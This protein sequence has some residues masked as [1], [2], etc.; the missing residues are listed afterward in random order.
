[1]SGFLCS[2]EKLRMYCLEYIQCNYKLTNLLQPLN[3]ISPN[4]ILLTLKPPVFELFFPVN[5]HTKIIPYI[6]VV[7][8]SIS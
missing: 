5:M 7:F 2:F 3:G 6:E 8:L 1:M 4:N